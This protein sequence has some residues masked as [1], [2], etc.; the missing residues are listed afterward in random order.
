[1]LT[2][3]PQIAYRQTGAA[4]RSRYVARALTKAEIKQEI[5]D[6]RP[7][8]AGISPSGFPVNSEP[9]HAVVIVGYDEEESQFTI[10]VNDPY[11]Y[12]AINPG[13]NPYRRAGGQDNRNGSYSISI[14]D[15][16]NRLMW[17]ASFFGIEP[18]N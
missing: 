2:G 1:M 17:S 13:Y 10:T 6:N 7:I 5:D 4:L 8:I 3:Y 12:N 15:F 9:E 11:P 16:K 14:T 18:R